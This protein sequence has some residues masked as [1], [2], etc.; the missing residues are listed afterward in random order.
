MPGA[1]LRPKS[2]DATDISG[3]TSDF[4]R[5]KG[6]G[7]DRRPG[8]AD[9]YGR[10]GG[11]GAGDA[12]AAGRAPQCGRPSVGDPVRATRRGPRP[13]PDSRQPTGPQVVLET[14]P[15]ADALAQRGQELVHL[16]QE[17]QV[18]SLGRR[19]VDHIGDAAVADHHPAVSEQ[20]EDRVVG[21]HQHDLVVADKQVQGPP[22]VDAGVLDL[23]DQDHR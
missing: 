16:G 20:R 1:F 12:A 19:G 15:V 22:P 13:Q 7:G 18:G 4:G 17:R 2:E 14:I 21:R 10:R 11:G 23:V 8:A 5:G 6:C 9:Q 3:A